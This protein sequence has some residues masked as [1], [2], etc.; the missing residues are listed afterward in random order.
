MNRKP[1]SKEIIS[2]TVNGEPV[3]LAVEP[4]W[5]LLE[6]VRKQLGLTG[7]KRSCDVGDCGACTVLLDG[8]PVNACLVLAIEVDGSELLTVEGLAAAAGNNGHLHPLQDQFLEYNAA[9]CGYCTPGML[10]AA[11]ALLD[12]N[13]N[14]T[15]EEIRFAIAGNLCRCTGYV[16]IIDAI[17][18][19]A[20]SSEVE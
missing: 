18:A 3:E 2:F 16:K 6:V 5:T 12:Q 15:E 9:Q 4:F 14:P 13:P 8:A 10:M 19:A 1:T 17:K 20:N 7:A 11:K